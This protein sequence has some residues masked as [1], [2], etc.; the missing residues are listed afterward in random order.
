MIR[1]E[2]ASR[3]PA[4]AV[5]G[6]RSPIPERAG[7][8]TMS[9]SHAVLHPFRRAG[10]AQDADHPQ[11]CF[12]VHR[13]EHPADPRLPEDHFQPAGL[14]VG[15]R[16]EIRF[17]G[18]QFGL[19]SALLRDG[20]N[21]L[22]NFASSRLRVKINALDSREAAKSRRE[23]PWKGSQSGASTENRLEGGTSDA[24]IVHSA[25]TCSRCRHSKHR[26][27]HELRLINMLSKFTQH[28]EI[29]A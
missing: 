5:C 18:E 22:Q 6:A 17:L 8:T 15:V 2:P 16:R 28:V 13:A 27:K 9:S 10:H 11:D 26:S 23:K 29:T 20:V 25:P 4:M 3:A 12:A 21:H 24:R 19:Q 14:A 7:W 1:A